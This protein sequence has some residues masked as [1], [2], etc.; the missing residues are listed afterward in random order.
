MVRVRDDGGDL[1]FCV[2]RQGFEAG[3]GRFRRAHKDDSQRR[4][5]NSEMEMARERKEK[6]RRAVFHEAL[7]KISSPKLRDS[8][9]SPLRGRD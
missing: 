7:N 1:E 2:M 4:H 6:F 5:A 9:G 8:Q 3:A